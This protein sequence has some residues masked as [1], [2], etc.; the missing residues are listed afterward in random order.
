MSIFYMFNISVYKHSYLFSLSIDSNV[1][2]FNCTK[3]K[4]RFILW[5]C[6]SKLA[7]LT[8]VKLKILQ[9]M[10]LMPLGSQ[11]LIYGEIQDMAAWSI[12]LLNTACQI[13]FLLHCW[14]ISLT[15]SDKSYVHSQSMS[16]LV[17][18]NDQ[19]SI[20]VLVALMTQPSIYVTII[21][22]YRLHLERECRFSEQ[23][24]NLLYITFTLTSLNTNNR[25]TDCMILLAYNCEN[26]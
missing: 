24:I 6:P 10:L 11:F 1:A 9:I 25:A 19:M 7:L 22:M 4:G 3:F 8:I 18:C 12:T 13:F 16:L 5:A 15:D 23:F 17:H 14:G 2:N 21:T 20:Q 26:S